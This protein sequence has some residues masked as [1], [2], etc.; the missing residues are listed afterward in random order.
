MCAVAV[1]EIAGG[2]MQPDSDIIYT[3]NDRSLIQNLMYHFDHYFCSARRP[4]VV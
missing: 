3:A 4:M 2:K 1:A